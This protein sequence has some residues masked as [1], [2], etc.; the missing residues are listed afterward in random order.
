MEHR[1]RGS[2]DRHADAA[3]LHD[4]V[5]VGYAL[6]D[7]PRGLGLAKFGDSIKLRSMEDDIGA[8]QRDRPPVLV[9]TSDFELLVEE[10][11]RALFAFA[12]LP[13]TRRRLPVAHPARI[14]AECTR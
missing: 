13:T 8:Q 10:D 4:Y 1:T 7:R 9:V 14:A 5:G 6:G 11:D 2:P 3:R 12:D